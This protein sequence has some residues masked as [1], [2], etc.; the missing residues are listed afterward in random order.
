MEAS[1]T[2]QVVIVD[3]KIKDGL[4]VI[5]FEELENHYLPGSCLMFIAVGDNAARERLFHEVENKGYEFFSYVSTKSSTWPDLKV[6]RNMLI[7]DG[8]VIQPYLS[9]D[10]GCIFFLNK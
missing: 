5:P 9:V 4:S 2:K 6:G 10:D 7:S 1:S 8:A 3:D